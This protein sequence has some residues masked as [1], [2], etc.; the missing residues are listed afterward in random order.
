MKGF[1]MSHFDQYGPDDLMQFDVNLDIP[2]FVRD[3]VRSKMKRDT[4][5][6]L[7]SYGVTNI[8]SN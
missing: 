8:P 3:A 4:I 2:A 1:I 6:G 5:F 7:P